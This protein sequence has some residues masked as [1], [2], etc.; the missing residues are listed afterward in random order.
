MFNSVNGVPNSTRSTVN[1]RFFSTRP[2]LE[3]EEMLDTG[4]TIDPSP[5][6]LTTAFEPSRGLLD[7]DNTSLF[8]SITS[9]EA[10]D[11][12]LRSIESESISSLTQP[13]SEFTMREELIAKGWIFPPDIPI[14]IVKY[15]LSRRE[16]A[17]QTQIYQCFDLVNLEPYANPPVHTPATERLKAWHKIVT[18]IPGCLPS[19]N[20]E[21][22]SPQIRLAFGP[23]G[24]DQVWAYEYTDLKKVLH[25][26]G[27][28]FWWIRR[29]EEHRMWF[30]M[31][32]HTELYGAEVKFPYGY[33]IKIPATNKTTDNEKLVRIPANERVFIPLG[34][35]VAEWARQVSFLHEHWNDGPPLPYPFH[36]YD[37]MQ[38]PPTITLR[39]KN[40]HPELPTAV[41]A[42]SEDKGKW[43]KGFLSTDD[44]TILSGERDTRYLETVIEG[45]PKPNPVL[46]NAE[47]RSRMLQFWGLDRKIEDVAEWLAGQ[48]G[49]KEKFGV[50][51]ND[52]RGEENLKRAIEE[53]VYESVSRAIR[54]TPIREGFY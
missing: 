5:A 48:R 39:F 54:N 14:E 16:L 35:D 11:Q 24:W 23:L 6:L 8:P 38:E 33:D 31:H 43:T 2:S 22:E 53:R 20:N 10:A 7:P 32:K 51:R 49:M 4:N 29:F 21:P 30:T 36:S 26:A 18:R 1:G 47:N 27:Y 37:R 45:G 46:T 12:P 42:N 9:R 17:M 40:V 52:R 13:D 19:R 15:S 25:N 34:K 28:K 3:D 50:R 44:L 41:I